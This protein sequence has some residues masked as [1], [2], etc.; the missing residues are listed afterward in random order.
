MTR[1]SWLVGIGEAQA[2]L[3]ETWREADSEWTKA[4]TLALWAPARAC[5]CLGYWL[6]VPPDPPAG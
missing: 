3:A 4:W 6:V 5:F 1:Y 2:W